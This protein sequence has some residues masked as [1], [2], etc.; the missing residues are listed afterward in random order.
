MNAK[1][2]LDLTDNIQPRPPPVWCSFTANERYHARET[3]A[4][5]N[6][7]LANN[8]LLR[9]CQQASTSVWTLNIRPDLRN[10]CFSLIL[11]KMFSSK[12]KDVIIIV[13]HACSIS[14]AVSLKRYLLIELNRP[15]KTFG[16]ILPINWYTLT[17]SNQMSTGKGKRPHCSTVLLVYFP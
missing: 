7:C 1:I 4:D 14:A 8:I 15:G 5:S 10:A 3:T 17:S 6:M 12:S 11:A 2:M 16:W 13:S 9:F